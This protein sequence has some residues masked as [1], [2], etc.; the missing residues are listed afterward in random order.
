MDAPLDPRASR[1][2]ALMH[3]A[4]AEPVTL[5]EL[6]IAGI[7]D[8]AHALHA[9]E[10]AGFTFERVIDRTAARREVECVRLGHPRP[11][12]PTGVW[13]SERHYDA[14]IAKRPLGGA[15]GAG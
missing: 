4:D 9:L 13:R 6:Q 10:L 11:H 7:E 15:G 3:E 2:L 12:H 1:L 14:Q 8:P 5:D